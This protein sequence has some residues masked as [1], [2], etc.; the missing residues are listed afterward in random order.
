MSPKAI[1]SALLAVFALKAEATPEYVT[2]AVYAEQLAVA[3]RP[4]PGVPASTPRDG[5]AGRSTSMVPGAFVLPA[6]RNK[7]PVLPHAQ[8]RNGCR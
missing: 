6:P 5:N 3:V 1:L 7:T 8:C 2:P 4:I